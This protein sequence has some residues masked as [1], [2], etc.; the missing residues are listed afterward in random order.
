VLNVLKE[1]FIKH[2]KKSGATHSL[3]VLEIIHTVICGPFNVTTVDGLN[4]IITFTDDYSH[5]GC[6]Y[7]IRERSEA[8]EKFK[9]F[10]AEVENQ[11]DTKIKVVRS[12]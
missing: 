12:D 9:V 3:G 6:I 11:H 8:L 5:Y 4:S 2:I 10:K 7:P 1:K